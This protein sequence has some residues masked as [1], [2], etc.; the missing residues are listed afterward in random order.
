MHHFG[1]CAEFSVRRLFRSVFIL[2]VEIHSTTASGSRQSVFD[3][4]NSSSPQ[5][6]PC[7]TT[8][9]ASRS[10]W[11]SYVCTVSESNKATTLAGAARDS[12]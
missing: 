6:K 3:T 7:L 4:D 5:P 12:L 2:D 9:V 1:D 10:T 11:I 8:S